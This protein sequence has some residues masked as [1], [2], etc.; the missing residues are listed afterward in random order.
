MNGDRHR[1]LRF[2]GRHEEHPPFRAQVGGRRVERVFYIRQRR[3]DHDVELTEDLVC[4]RDG[5]AEHRR[6]AAFAGDVPRLAAAVDD[7]AHRLAE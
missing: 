4:A 3:I 1:L 5:G 6:R 2:R 7:L